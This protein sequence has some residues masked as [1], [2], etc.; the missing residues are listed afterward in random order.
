[1][2]IRSG[3]LEGGSVR[4]LDHHELQPDR[5]HPRRVPVHSDV[6]RGQAHS[7]GDRRDRQ[8][9]A[10]GQGLRC[11]QLAPDLVPV[12]PDGHRDQPGDLLERH[13]H[14]IR[15]GAELAQRGQHEGSPDV[16][17]PG[18]RDLPA[19]G[20]DAH[21]P[22]VAL[23]GGE[24]ERRLGVV[25]LPGDLLHLGVAETLGIQHHRQRVAAEPGVGEDI[26]GDETAAHGT[27]RG[28]RV[29][30]MPTRAPRQPSGRMIRAG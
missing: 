29:P 30:I 13:L 11:P 14:G 18:E 17:M 20:E 25:E 21:A 9:G 16:R 23:L 28:D 22:V 27:S 12:A 15:E 2:H 5:G 4:N 24:H 26:A 19:G 3:P 7:V 1:M 10:E 6:L 8:L